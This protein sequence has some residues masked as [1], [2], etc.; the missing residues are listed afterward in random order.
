VLRTPRLLLRRL[1]LDDA[2]AF[3]YVWGDP[4]VIWWGAMP[5]VAATRAFLGKVLQR[6]EGDEALGWFAV[7]HRDERRLIGDVALQPAH[8]DDAVE[9]GW[10]IAKDNQNHGYATEAAGALLD[11]ARTH[12][13]RHVEAVIV[14]D[15]IASH[16]VAA[17]LGMRRTGRTVVQTGLEHDL[18]VVDLD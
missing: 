6:V 13:I 4:R 9:I 2:E 12:D 17:H 14:P 8:W 5:D 18:Y 3:H 16:R 15:N 1:T 7:I 10:H 11:H